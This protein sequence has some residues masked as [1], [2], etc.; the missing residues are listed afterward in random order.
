MFLI[1]STKLLLDQDELVEPGE[2]AKPELPDELLDCN[3]ELVR[4]FELSI[5][6]KINILFLL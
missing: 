4:P 6:I 3:I 2:E 1:I 5:I